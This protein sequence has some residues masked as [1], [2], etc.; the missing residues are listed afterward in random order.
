MPCSICKHNGHNKRTCTQE[1][2]TLDL[3]YKKNIKKFPHFESDYSTFTHFQRERKQFYTNYSS[4]KRCL[5]YHTKT[6]PQDLNTINNHQL[7]LTDFPMIFYHNPHYFDDYL[8]T[9]KDVYRYTEKHEPIQPNFI[10]HLNE[11][12]VSWVY[13]DRLRA[14]QTRKNAKNLLE[15]YN[16]V[17]NKNTTLPIRPKKEDFTFDTHDE[18]VNAFNKYTKLK[19]LHKNTQCFIKAFSNAHRPKYNNKRLNRFV[20]ILGQIRKFKFYKHL[21]PNELLKNPTKNKLVTSIPG[22]GG[23]KKTKA[24]ERLVKTYVSIVDEVLPLCSDVILH[25]VTF[26]VN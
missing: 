20:N 8:T 23:I 10:T 18:F 17:V 13:T 19:D 24:I 25:I 26:L 4:Q 9:S 6:Y 21:Y 1:N 7:M 2:I 16:P 3:K 14:R 5:D 12:N 11:V 15:K 22:Y